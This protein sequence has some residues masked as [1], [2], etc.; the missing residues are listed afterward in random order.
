MKNDR[1]YFDAAKAMRSGGSFAF[2]ISEA[3]FAA[4]S[5]NKE[6]LLNA[7]KEL[8]DSFVHS[9]HNEV[10]DH[11]SACSPCS[12]KTIEHFVKEQLPDDVDTGDIVQALIDKGLITFDHSMQAYEVTA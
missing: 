7:F 11:I 12:F 9:Y 5:A 1:K 8:F 3:Y 2:A 10:F 6:T 4:D